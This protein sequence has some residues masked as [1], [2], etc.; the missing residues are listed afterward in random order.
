MLLYLLVNLQYFRKNMIIKILALSSLIG[1]PV[2]IIF[3]A[4]FA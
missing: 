3:Y 2:L 1:K 4:R